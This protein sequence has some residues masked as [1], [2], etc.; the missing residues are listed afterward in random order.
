[1]IDHL[2]LLVTDPK[3]SAAFYA[4]ALK[5]LGYAL[6]VEGP[7]LGFG[8]TDD[9]LDFWLKPGGPSKPLPHFAFHCVSRALV[10]RCYRAAVENGGKEDRAP[11]LMPRVHPNYYAGFVFDR[12]GH[13]VE[14]VCHAG[15]GAA[16]I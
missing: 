8:A 9:A 10:D 4:G 12:D 16:T 15:D 6:R 11:A 2:E 5:P 7:A 3:Q 14:F 1:M 13:L